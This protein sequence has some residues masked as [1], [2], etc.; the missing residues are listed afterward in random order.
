MT[1]HTTSIVPVPQLAS[2]SLAHPKEAAARIVAVALACTSAGAIS[3]SL[4][5]TRDLVTGWARGKSSPSLVQILQAPRSFRL[6]LTALAGRCY[7]P[8]EVVE[9]P[10]RERL[11]LLWTAVGVLMAT[12]RHWAPADELAARDEAELREMVESA[13][14][15][16][17]E[18]EKIAQA[19]TRELVNRKARKGA[20]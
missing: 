2:V 4:D 8:S 17:S 12:P 9:V 14:K 7:E 6:R 15:L 20:R 19:A 10:I 18:A 11:W 3:S 1:T 13:T 16:A 5:C